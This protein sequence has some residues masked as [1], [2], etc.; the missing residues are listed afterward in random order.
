MSDLANGLKSPLL[1]HPKLSAHFL[2]TKNFFHV[3]AIF[4]FAILCVLTFIYSNQSV[5]NSTTQTLKF[6]PSAYE[7]PLSQ[8]AKI[9]NGNTSHIFVNS[10]NINSNVR[11]NQYEGEEEDYP[12]KKDYRQEIKKVLQE[13]RE[14]IQEELFGY[15]YPPGISAE[16]LIP[17]KGGKPLQSVIITTWRSGSTFLGDVLQSVPATMY[18][19]E[20]L[21]DFD[22]LQIRGAPIAGVALKRLKKLLTCN[23]TGLEEDYLSYGQEHTWLL[24]HNFRLWNKCTVRPYLCWEPQ[25]LSPFCKLFPFQIMKVVRVRLS[26]VEELLEDNNL[27]VRILLMVRDPRGTMQSRRHREWCPGHPDCWDPLRL[28][29][30]L[31][32]D[33]SAA[34]RLSAKYPKRFKA[35]RYEDLSLEPYKMVEELFNFFGLYLHPKVVEFLDT[36]TKNNIGGVSSTYRD[37]KSAPF[38]WRTDLDHSQVKSIQKV[39]KPA[40]HLWGYVLAHNQ[41]HQRVFNPILPSFQLV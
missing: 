36:H 15:H 26:L 31:V 7:R 4:V 40:M 34:L 41:T 16:K 11:N 25:F 12:T 5:R 1:S 20:P 18:H 2:R 10:R 39:C 23:Y 32:A 38:H 9:E 17:E 30:D 3:S 21:L 6:I 14:D 13:T 33:Y 27:N 24:E 29:A 35:I 19:Y 8:R 37:S 28:C 22:I